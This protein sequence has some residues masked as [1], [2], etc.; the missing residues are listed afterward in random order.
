[1]QEDAVARL[2]VIDTAHQ[3]RRGQATHGHGGS[4]LE[5]DGVR[6]L[7]QRSGRNQTLGAIGTER[8][9]ET[10]VSNTVAD[11]HIGHPLPHRQ[12]YASSLNPHAIG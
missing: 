11:H 6:Q 12:H 7:D 4:R 3:I 10:G 5:S 8:V 9:E 2:E 1:M